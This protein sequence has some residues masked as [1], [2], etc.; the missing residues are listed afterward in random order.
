MFFNQRTTMNLMSF[1]VFITALLVICSLCSV[2]VIADE[3]KEKI[4]SSSTEN[5]KPLEALHLKGMKIIET[6]AMGSDKSSA[7]VYFQEAGELGYLESQLMLGDMYAFGF[8]IAPSY[9][10]AAY[11]FKKAANQ[12]SS[13]AQ[14]YMGDLYFEGL[15]VEK[16]IEKGMAYMQK[17]LQNPESDE[18][19]KR[20]AKARMQEFSLSNDD[21][22]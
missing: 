9:E 13:R 12:G 22:H 8:G 10:G 5:K 16:N 6:G 21:A 7:V 19:S 3:V 18:K 20:I 15:G 11:W 2:A 17:A 4:G 14:L 1:R